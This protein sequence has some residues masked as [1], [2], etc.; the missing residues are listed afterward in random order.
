MGNIS[1]VRIQMPDRNEKFYPLVREEFQAQV[2]K[3][4]WRNIDKL[5]DLI[6]AY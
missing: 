1:E 3:I 4:L 5:T 6:E 2:I